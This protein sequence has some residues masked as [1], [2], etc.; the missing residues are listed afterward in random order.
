MLDDES[1]LDHVNLH[2][3]CH[4]FKLG[5]LSSYLHQIDHDVENSYSNVE[6][7]KSFLMTL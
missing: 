1:I 7:H 4:R 5:L 6:L 2:F 3:C